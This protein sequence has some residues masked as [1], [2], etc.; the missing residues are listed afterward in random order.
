M[1]PT[2]FFI[3]SQEAFQV[4]STEFLMGTDD[5]GRDIFSG[6]VQGLRNSIFVSLGVTFISYTLGIALGIISGLLGGIT[7]QLCLK[8]SEIIMILPRFL[9][10]ILATSFVGQ[11]ILILIIVLG[12]FSWTSIYRI[13]RSEI[14]SLRTRE[15]I[16]AAKALGSSVGRISIRHLFP[17]YFLLRRQLCLFQCV[18]Q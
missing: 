9:I 10:I 4:P 16:L 11:G 5:L 6:V 12:L 8:F 18:M 7:D 14:L 17:A 3:E 15:Y 1:A 13:I 2:S